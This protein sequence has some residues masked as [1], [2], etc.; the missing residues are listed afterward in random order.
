MEGCR[1]VRGCST[2]FKVQTG[3]ADTKRLSVRSND[4]SHLWRS[5]SPEGVLPNLGI[6]FLCVPLNAVKRLGCGLR[7]GTK[8]FSLLPN[9]MMDKRSAEFGITG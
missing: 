8:N 9:D 6:H 7:V 4:F 2:L 1:E 5:S 3:E